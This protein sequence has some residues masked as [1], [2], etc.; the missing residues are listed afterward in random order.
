MRSP[1]FLALLLSASFAWA[2]RS[3]YTPPTAG[4][5]DEPTKPSVQREFE[6]AKAQNQKNTAPPIQPPSEDL[7]RLKQD[8][9]ELAFL[10]QS[11]PP[12]VDQTAKGILPKDLDPKLRKIEKLAKQLR[13]RISH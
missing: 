2:Q 3:G 5:E 6:M 7:A 10:A 11:I 13:S 9:A 8:A 1:V 12:D 4:R